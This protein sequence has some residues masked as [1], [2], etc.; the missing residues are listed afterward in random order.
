MKKLF[1]N[2]YLALFLTITVFFYFVPVHTAHAGFVADIVSDVVGGVA[3]AVSS[4]VDF[5]A[6]N[7]GTIVII[8]AAVVFA[9]VAIGALSSM[10]AGVGAGISAS[11]IA[12]SVAAGLVVDLIMPCASGLTK[13]IVSTVAGGGIN[14][15]F[16]LGTGVGL[17]SSGSSCGGGNN[18][19]ASAVGTVVQTTPVPGGVCYGPLNSCGQ[20]YDGVWTGDI[21]CSQTNEAG[22]CTAYSGA[23]CTASTS[24]PPESGCPQPLSLPSCAVNPDPS[25]INQGQVSVLV[26]GCQ[27]ADSATMDNGIGSVPITSMGGNTTNNPNFVSGGR[28]SWQQFGVSPLNTT[29][30]N[31]TAV[32]PGGTAS[33]PITVTV[34]ATPAPNCAFVI[35]PDV[36]NQGQS[37]EFVWGCQNATSCS[38]D[39]GI[40]NVSAQNGI[41]P[42]SPS[43]TAT[44]TLSCTGPGGSSSFP[45]PVTVNKVPAAVTS[46]ITSPAST[47]LGTPATLSWTSTNADTCNIDNGIGQ[48]APNSS[49]SVNPSQTTTYTITCTGAGGT[50]AP[51]S[52][53]LTVYQPPACSSFSASP[54]QIV[55]GN[56]STLS[57]TCSNSNSCSLSAAQ[58]T[59]FSGTGSYNVSPNR[60]TDYTLSCTGNGGTRTF[61]TSVTVY[62]NPVCIFSSSPSTI[63]PPQSSTLSWSCTKA[64]SCRVTSP[65]GTLTTGGASGSA[66]VAPRQTTSYTLTCTGAGNNTIQAQSSF[67]TTLT[68]TAY[69]IIEGQP[70]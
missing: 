11:A 60:T 61:G 63:V 23:T 16:D 25:T 36:I 6:D 70:Q 44:Y 48:V 50:S 26:W 38:I 14:S 45:V 2:K 62:E 10:V 8:A 9:P 34:N 29:T 13:F 51:S 33:F 5:V 7:I 57:W 66:S 67:Q 54:S 40:G 12:V 4:V 3:D 52:A 28:K 42:F 37:A 32:G 30:Y 56:Q 41:Q 58:G 1:G 53:T 59:A 18:I 64:T 21:Y 27:N 20:A 17:P 47:P 49:T 24:A 55:E 35:N 43:Q 19:P 31:L 68:V 15:A 65:S 46:V 39:N 22:A 69:K